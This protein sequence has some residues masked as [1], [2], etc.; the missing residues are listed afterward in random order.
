MGLIRTG[1]IFALAYMLLTFVPAQD[2][3]LGLSPDDQVTIAKIK[4]LTTSIRAD[5]KNMTLADFHLEN[6]P[7]YLQDYS[8]QL[9]EEC[10]SGK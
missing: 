2:L 5:C 9:A 7:A 6:D 1:T 3:S 10:I 8:R 4:S